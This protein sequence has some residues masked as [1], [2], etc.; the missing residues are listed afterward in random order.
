MSQLFLSH[1]S[2]DNA[3]A[4]GLHGWLIEQ[5]W[6]DL[7]LDLDPQQGIVAGERWE[8]ALYQ[9]ANRCDAVLFLISQAWLSSDWCWREF[10]LAQKLNKQLFILLIE[11]IPIDQLPGELTAHWQLVNLAGGSDHEAP[12]EVTLPDGTPAWV[13]FSESGL[14]RLKAGL[15]RLERRPAPRLR[16]RGPYPEMPGP[17]MWRSRPWAARS[18][19]TKSGGRMARSSGWWTGIFSNT[20]LT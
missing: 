14:A 20:R 13:L 10:R 19:A 18:R 9:A 6:D 8:R 12:R 2:I 5:G 3:Q 17:A 4:L 11:D 7:F 1:S 16:Q 15:S